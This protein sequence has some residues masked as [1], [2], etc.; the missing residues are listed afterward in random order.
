MDLRAKQQEALINLVA[1]VNPD[2]EKSMA[3]TD[4]FN[5]VRE[6]AFNIA[7][8]VHM[9]Q[10]DLAGKPYI[11]HPLR[12]ASH[13]TNLVG[14]CAAL[15]HDAI[16]DGKELGIT[17]HFLHVALNLPAV[18]VSAVEYLSRREGETYGQYLNRVSLNY[19]AT[20][21]KID[22][23]I[24]NSNVARYDHPT[25]D[26]M[27]RCQRYLGKVYSLKSKC[28]FQH[29]QLYDIALDMKAL[30]AV[31]PMSYYPE[32]VYEDDGVIYERIYFG[33]EGCLNRSYTIIFNCVIN[34]DGT[35]AMQVST[36]PRE[37]EYA[38]KQ[39][40]VPKRTT[41][42][43]GAKDEA[44]EYINNVHRLFV[45]AGMK[46]ASKDDGLAISRFPG[47]ITEENFKAQLDRTHS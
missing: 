3:I 32:E 12:V 44:M 17:P 31:S 23:G 40:Y 33:Y 13:A 20:K 43:F 19:E 46:S 37:K 16:E 24:D 1:Q 29:G 27:L 36:Y 25:H 14:Y 28:E 45:K 39:F 41:H 8:I 4:Y 34:D 10:F 15:L 18:I 26:Q 30:H 5:L 38:E 42:K 22:D 2:E 9:G 47:A 6:R 7:Q 35:V 11:Q 21:V